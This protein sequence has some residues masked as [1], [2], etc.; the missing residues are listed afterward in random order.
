MKKVYVVMSLYYNHNEGVP[1]SSIHDYSIDSVWSLKRDAI[2]RI[3]VI[4]DEWTRRPHFAMSDDND[5]LLVDL[6]P[7]QRFT[8]N[9]LTFTVD[10]VKSS[11]I[12]APKGIEVQ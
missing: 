12:P 3:H 9:I 11:Y 10:P 7:L 5:S 2:S 1:I 6:D 4:R 8:Y